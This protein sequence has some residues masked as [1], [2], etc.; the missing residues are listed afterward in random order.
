[1]KQFA[2]FITR[3][4]AWTLNYSN[5]EIIVISL[6]ILALAVLLLYTGIK[7]I[8]VMI[9]PDDEDDDL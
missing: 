6:A 4:S 1:M 7:V 8:E 9:F 5:G 3:I 2:D